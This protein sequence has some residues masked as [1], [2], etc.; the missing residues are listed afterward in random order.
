MAGPVDCSVCDKSEERC[1]CEKYCS[2]CK[3]QHGIRLCIDGQYYCP[4]CREACDVRV[5]DTRDR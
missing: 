4:E 3:G 1:E 2:I 5:V